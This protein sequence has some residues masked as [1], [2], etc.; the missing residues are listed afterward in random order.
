VNVINDLL[1][2]ALKLFAKAY[3][4]RVVKVIYVSISIKCFLKS[5]SR[6][7]D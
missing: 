4:L 7:L 3:Q 1:S 5:F 2:V 6:T